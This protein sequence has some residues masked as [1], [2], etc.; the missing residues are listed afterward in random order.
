MLVPHRIHGDAFS[1][2]RYELKYLI[3]PELIDP[4]ISFIRP[5]CRMDPFSERAKDK[6][7]CI[8]TLYLDSP[9]YRTYWDVQEKAA[10]R[11]KLRIRIYGNDD[12][13]LVK[14]EIKR[15]FKDIC[16]KTTVNVHDEMWP[17]L[18][19]LSNHK[20]RENSLQPDNPALLE[21]VGLAYRIRAEPKMLISYERKAFQSTVDRYVRISFD[22]RICHQ[23]KYICDFTSRPENW[24][25][26]DGFDSTGV[27]G[28]HVVL[29]LKLMTRAPVWIVDLVRR[30]GLVREG[31]S[32]YCT[33]VTQALTQD[34]VVR[35]QFQSK[36]A[37]RKI[38]R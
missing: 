26:N 36:P 9:D 22:R 16:L 23:T 5:Y 21:F 4:I 37:I 10:S 11:F 2:Q 35:E 29:E 1:L 14:F 6:Y 15:R 34:Q 19:E 27:I 17:E 12:T 30:F 13:G 3:S 25:Y 31:F 38:G 8:K 20:H 18:L 7:Y 33:A 28:P 24:I 32:K